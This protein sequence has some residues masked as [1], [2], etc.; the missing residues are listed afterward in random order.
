MDRL[1]LLMTT[2]TMI[3]MHRG[4]ALIAPYATTEEP[5]ERTHMIHSASAESIVS[6]VIAFRSGSLSLDDAAAMAHL[7]RSLM[8]ELSEVQ[9]RSGTDA[10]VSA[11]SDFKALEAP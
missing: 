4:D 9:E 3:S 7:G 8:R 1:L 10:L 5:V 6:A 2:T 11:V